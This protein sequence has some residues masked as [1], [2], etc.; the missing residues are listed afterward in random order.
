SFSLAAR[1][2]V[3]E[4]GTGVAG[5][6]RKSR[7]PWSL[8]CKKICIDMWRCCR[9]ETKLSIYHDGRAKGEV[10]TIMR[11]RAVFAVF[12]TLG[13]TFGQDPADLFSKAPPAIDEVLRS[14]ITEF[15]QAHKEGKFRLA[16]KLV[17]EESKDIF[18]EADKRR[19]R[20]FKI[21][22]VSYEEQFT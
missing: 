4:C 12:C 9:A 6:S 16:E 5:V 8:P 11:M 15:Y 2:S 1:P 17:A 13:L 10:G 14:R 18:F 7:I 21:A 22:R 3:S 19:C 20:E